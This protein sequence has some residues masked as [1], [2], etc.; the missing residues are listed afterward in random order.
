MKVNAKKPKTTAKPPPKTLH[1]K[2]KA[3]YLSKTTEASLRQLPDDVRR[4]IMRVKIKEI[5]T[6]LNAITQCKEVFRLCETLDKETR[7][8]CRLAKYWKLKLIQVMPNL[9]SIRIQNDKLTP[10]AMNE[11]WRIQEPRVYN[12]PKPGDFRSIYKFLCERNAMKLHRWHKIKSLEYSKRDG[13]IASEYNRRS[14]QE[15]IR[16]LRSYHMIPPNFNRMRR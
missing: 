13:L 4:Q 9:K 11:W 14:E 12:L 3:N 1:Q 8:E 2:V 10:E 16:N 15:T 7:K 5:I 6:N